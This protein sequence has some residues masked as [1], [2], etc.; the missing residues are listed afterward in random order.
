MQI[1]S[2]INTAY[3]SLKQPRL[4]ARYLLELAGVVNDERDTALILHF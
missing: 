1:T 4:R 3:T 2:H